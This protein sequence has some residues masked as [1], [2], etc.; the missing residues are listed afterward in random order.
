[1]KLHMLAATFAI[2]LPFSFIYSGVLVLPVQSQFL[3]SVHIASDGSVIGTD[4]IQRD[5]DVY[6][7]KADIEGG[8]QVQKSN[9]VIDGAGYTVQGSGEGRGLDLSSEAEEDPSDQIISNVTVKNMRIVNFYNGILADG[10]NNTFYGNYVADCA[11]EGIWI[12]GG[13]DNTIMGNTIENN[14][15]GVSICFSEGSNV[16]TKNNMINN[17]VNSKNV[18]IVWLSTQPSIDGNYWSDYSGVDADDDGV[19]DTPYAID[20]ENYDNYPLMAPFE[21]S[22]SPEPQPG[23]PFL[24]PLIIA[25]VIAVAFVGVGLLIYF[26]RRKR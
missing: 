23:E 9:I 10:Q 26:K 8:I 7:L 17:V 3:G 2:A 15:N 16:I 22:P 21:A 13:S 5:G 20:G 11:A 24:T 18:I 1:M 6:T 19:G 25:F 4:N 14:V 12:L